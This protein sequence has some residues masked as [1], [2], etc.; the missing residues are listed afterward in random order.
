ML[1]TWPHTFTI[2]YDIATVCVYIA[3][4]LDLHIIYNLKKGIGIEGEKS[5]ETS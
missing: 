3:N 1:L 2:A 5:I 4:G